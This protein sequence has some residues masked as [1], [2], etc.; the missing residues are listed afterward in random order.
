MTSSNGVRRVAVSASD[1]RCICGRYAIVTE[2]AALAAAEWA[3]R[4]DEL[5]A[6]AAARAAMAAELARTPIRAR[7]VAGRSGGPCCEALCVGDEIGSEVGPW[8]STTLG[9]GAWL[10]DAPEPWDLAVDPIQAPNLLARGADGA[11]AMIAAGPAGSLLPVPEMYMQKLIVPAEAVG[12]IDLDAP[13]AEN[14]KAVAAALGRPAEQLNVVVLDR[15]RHEDLIEQIRRTGA[16]IRL[17]TDGD[18]SAGLAVA[19]G[20]AGVDMY[21]GIGGSTEGILAAAA[22]QCLG[23]EMQARFW[24]VS[25]HQVELV[26]SAGIEDIE[27]L[28]STSDMAG[29]GVL[30]AATAVTGGRFLRA[31]SYRRDGIHTET[32]VLCSRC[33]AVRKIQTVHR[34]ENRGPRVILGSR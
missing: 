22:L 11:L 2:A 16:R 19:S 25:R 23:G 12:K 10:V 27:T 20:D 14:V 21:V 26:K 32:L 28:L 18:V 3:G 33:R 8:V 30:F 1:G 7:I 4:G 31:V 29:E 34:S 24:P 5:A 6:V 15:P 9:E 17:I 13:V